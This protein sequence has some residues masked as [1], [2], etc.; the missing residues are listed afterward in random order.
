MKKMILT[1]LA[2]L[3]VF[4]GAGVFNQSSAAVKAEAGISA[5]DAEEQTYTVIITDIGSNKVKVIKILRAFLEIDLKDAYDKASKTPVTVKTKV[6][7]EDAEKIKA[8]LV[9]AGAKVELK[10]EKKAS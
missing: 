2:S 9:E 5:P 1:L 7:A 10:A 3:A 4:A 8:E 6:P